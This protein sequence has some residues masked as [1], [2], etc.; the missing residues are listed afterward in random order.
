VTE[1]FL[2]CI[3]Q[4]GI[5]FEQA[6]ARPGKWPEVITIAA[7][8]PVLRAAILHRTGDSEP[9]AVFERLAAT[10]ANVGGIRAAV[11]ANASSS[12]PHSS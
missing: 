10:A 4:H 11:S 3:K 2:D 12:A 7:E 6:A 8:R 9:A 5:S 1:E